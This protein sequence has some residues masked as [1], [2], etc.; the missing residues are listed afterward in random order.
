MRMGMHKASALCFIVDLLHQ[1]KLLLCVQY[2]YWVRQSAHQEG[3][4]LPS[5]GIEGNCSK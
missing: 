3:K 4:D 2:G 1:I 5:L